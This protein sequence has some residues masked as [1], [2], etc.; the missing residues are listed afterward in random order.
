[1]KLH[2]D[3]FNYTK[4]DLLYKNQYCDI[5]PYLSG[6]YQLDLLLRNH[7]WAG[8]VN[9][10]TTLTY[11]IVN[12]ESEA[13]LH[14]ADIWSN[15]G[16]I[17]AQALE[18]LD[19]HFTISFSIPEDKTEYLVDFIEDND[20]RDFYQ[21]YETN[22]KSSSEN[23]EY[24]L[25]IVLENLKR[26]ITAHPENAKLQKFSWLKNVK[27]I[28]ELSLNKLKFF[29]ESF[30]KKQVTAS[31]AQIEKLS[32]MFKYTFNLM[33]EVANITFKETDLDEDISLFTGADLAYNG[34]EDGY[35]A[36]E[37]FSYSNGKTNHVELKP[38]RSLSGS[39]QP[40]VNMDFDGTL[41]GIGHI[42]IDHPNDAT[43]AVRENL[44][45][46][47]HDWSHRDEDL[48]ISNDYRADSGCMSVMAFTK[49][50]YQGRAFDDFL[51]YM[52]IDIQAMQHIYGRNEQ[53][54]SGDTTYILAADQTYVDKVE[55]PM[56][57]IS[58]SG[59]YHLINNEYNEKN[60]IYTLY[61]AGG[62]NS[63][64]LTLVDNAEIDLN[65]GAGHFN[66]IGDN[67]FLIAYGV[68]I[69]NV[70][71]GSGNIN[72][73]LNQLDN[74]IVVESSGAHII[75]ENFSDN[76]N[77]ILAENANQNLEF[78]GCIHPYSNIGD[79]ETTICFN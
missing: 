72:I 48:R 41:H 28:D 50:Y 70:K 69:H 1:M 71:V 22:Y 24:R 18:Y 66:V 36:I 29:G 15:E 6:N 17:I 63:F 5:Q 33:S 65:Q 37:T 79:V 49:C 76:D 74:N 21:L 26:R 77:L 42:V 45:P 73:K 46:P 62:I 52:P 60:F 2:L 54:R 20:N 55:S 19:D 38:A 61:D 67:Y 78:S 27:S 25:S 75:I 47:D 31:K 3:G 44:L 68:N 13:A 7:N 59:Q 9:K 4:T 43:I 34:G 12:N 14:K 35:F 8:G 40:F 53:T 39:E 58:L 51:T 56:F 64:D 30:D 16:K 23:K 10:P 11:K 57:P 32:A